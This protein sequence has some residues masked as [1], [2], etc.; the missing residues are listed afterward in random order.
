M[1][2]ARIA[3][4]SMVPENTMS[5]TRLSRRSR[6]RNRGYHWCAS[7]AEDFNLES[8]TSK[9]FAFGKVVVSVSKKGLL[10]MP[11]FC[12]VRC[13]RSR[14]PTTSL[15]CCASRDV[16]YI[17]AL[18]CRELGVDRTPDEDRRPSP[19]CGQTGSSF[20]GQPLGRHRLKQHSYLLTFALITFSRHTEKLVA[21]PHLSSCSS[22]SIVNGNLDLTATIEH[23]RPSVRIAAPAARD[24]MIR[25]LQIVVQE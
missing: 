25:T 9:C 24:A 5:G 17:G 10:A 14:E 6:Q 1:N 11:N 23:R 15:R 8:P 3:A 21:E 22:D 7:G 4:R 19:R 2:L 13:C 16:L 18:T 20:C 12:V